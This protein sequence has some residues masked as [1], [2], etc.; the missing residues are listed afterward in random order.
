MSPMS[1]VFEKT[2]VPADRSRINVADPVEV[3]WWSRLL[4]CSPGQLLEAVARAGD[5]AA[6][7]EHLVDFW[8]GFGLGARSAMSERVA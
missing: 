7:V 2:R 4:G 3:R 6:R 8:Q 1:Y 5:S